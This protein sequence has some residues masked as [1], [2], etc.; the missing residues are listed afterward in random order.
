MAALQRIYLVAALRL[1]GQQCS[2]SCSALNSDQWQE[3]GQLRLV[4]WKV[5][6]KAVAAHL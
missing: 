5:A 1:R 2:V 6:W 3:N 4:F